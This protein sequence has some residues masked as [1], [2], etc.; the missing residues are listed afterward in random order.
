MLD[1]SYRW[2]QSKKI[3]LACAS[4][5]ILISVLVLV[6]WQ[7]SIPEL[8]KIFP[9]YISMK[10]NTAIG[11]FLFGIV[12]MVI[13]FFNNEAVKAKVLIS[14]CTSLAF[15][16]ATLTLLQYASGWNLGI[17]EFM[18][19]DTEGI[20]RTYP[21]GRLA[22]ITAVSFVL[23]SLGVFF[24]FLSREKFFRFSQAMFFIVAILSFQAVVSYA[25]GVQTSFGIA[26]HT[27]MALHT[28]IAL[29]GLSIGFLSLGANHGFVKIV[30]SRTD[31]GATARR[32]IF[33]SLFVPPVVNFFEIWGRNA[34]FYESDFGV[35]LR[36]LGSMIFFVIMVLISTEKNYLVED[37]REQ[38]IL[39]VLTKEKESSRLQAEQE[40]SIE[41][42]VS[43]IRLR[44]ELIEA[45][46]RA[47]KAANAKAEFL[48]RMSHEIRTPL[49]GML[50]ISDLLGT[51]ELDA[52]QL[53]YVE[54][55]QSSG[56]LLLAIIND[57]L[58]FSKIEADKVELEKVSF[59]LKIIAQNQ[60]DLLS[61]QMTEKGLK[62][63]FYV[64]PQ[65][66]F[67]VSGDPVRVGQI[68]INF[69]GNA[70]K[71][72]SQ[73]SIDIRLDS[74]KTEKPGKAG[75]KFSVQDSG[76]GISKST[77]AKLFQPFSQAD[78][79]TSR[80]FGGTG[81]GL[82]I[83]Q[84]L[85]TLMG[86][87]IGVESEEGMGSTFWFSVEFDTVEGKFQNLNDTPVKPSLKT[88]WENI[89][90]LVAED[91]PVNQLVAEEHLRLLGIEPH[92]VVNGKK[93]VE[94][95]ATQKFDLILMDCQMPEMDGYSATKIIRESEASSNRRVPIIAL[96]AN[97]MAEDKAKCLAVGMDDYLPK[98]FDRSDLV[99][100]LNRWLP[101]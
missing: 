40:A 76:I 45:R 41:R 80:K 2:A 46:Q 65:I 78:S 92:S 34:G 58:D 5:V 55:L 90:V 91:N 83:C 26:S 89:S 86:G 7:F 56:S 63:T 62:S 25:L 31:S 77:L 101:A 75:V 17:D 52:K 12:Q 28:G 70:I 84:S 98:P 8:T 100:I 96:T 22:P 99:E 61:P 18:Y 48:A 73:G 85:V 74:F 54:T 30:F 15:L 20:G 59:N 42:E 68:L 47:E 69:M 3:G 6:G 88:F 27:R 16:L 94:A 71:F 24:E 37:D 82:S 53:R 66:P 49:N 4:L 11:L 64:D 93:A 19:V 50:G 79:S 35:L 81:L 95:L 36:V 10:A 38:A 32:L 43:Q 67:Q 39:A 13:V 57:I 21:P 87:Q 51:T 23:L 29:I 72:T 14:I 44:A 97:A 33:A 1:V 60:M 9:N